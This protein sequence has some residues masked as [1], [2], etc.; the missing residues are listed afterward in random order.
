DLGIWLMAFDGSD[1]RNLVPPPPAPAVDSAPMFSPD[2]TKVAFIRKY[3]TTPP[4]AREAAFIVNIDGTGLRQ[5]T[6]PALDVGRIRWSPDGTQLAFSDQTENRDEDTPQDIWLI[7]PDGSDLHRITHNTPGTQTF[8]PD[9]SPDGSRFA[10]LGWH[11][12]DDHNT[13]GTMNADGTALR[14]IYA[15]PSDA[16]L[17]WPAWGG[18]R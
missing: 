12:G 8:D 13:I 10:V 7:N 18:V 14:Q 9:W 17:Y 11:K 16:F 4:H 3:S 15:G 5:L 2:G 6:D 1:R